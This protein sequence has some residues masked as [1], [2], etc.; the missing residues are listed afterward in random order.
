M[1]YTK[2]VSGPF[3]DPPPLLAKEQGAAA[4]GTEKPT[5]Q[6][7]A[8]SIGQ[9]AQLSGAA[10]CSLGGDNLVSVRLVGSSSRL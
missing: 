10:L 8:F 4:G 7:S 3:L 1:L 6:L 2:Q 5:A 9:L